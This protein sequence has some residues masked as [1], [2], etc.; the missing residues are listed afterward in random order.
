MEE[1]DDLQ[2]ELATT[3]RIVGVLYLGTDLAIRV[4]ACSMSHFLRIVFANDDTTTKNTKARAH[5]SKSR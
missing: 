5:K 4:N 2:V 3:L 1:T